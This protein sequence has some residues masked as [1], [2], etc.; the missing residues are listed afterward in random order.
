MASESACESG[1][2]VAACLGLALEDRLA[3]LERPSRVASGPRVRELEDRYVGNGRAQELDLPLADRLAGCPGRELVDLRR[4]RV[5]VFRSHELDEERTRFWLGLDAPLLKLRCDPA[6]DL[7]LLHAVLEDVARLLAR[8]PER[9]RL[10]DVLPDERKHRTRSG[11]CEV[12]RD[13]TDVGRLPASFETP[14]RVA[15]PVDTLGDDKPSV[16]EEASRVAQGHHCVPR[17][18][19]RTHG[20]G[21]LRCEVGSKAG[22]RRFDLRPIAAREE[23]HRLA[24]SV[25]HAGA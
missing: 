18:V 6:L 1:C 23:I 17:S 7:L 8:F 20:V 3:R 12:A 13:L 25:G 11:A 15:P 21:G 19:E 2:R 16:A 9:R 14:V 5:Q 24:G 10:L 22:E 4:E